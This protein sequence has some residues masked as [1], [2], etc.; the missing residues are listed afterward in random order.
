MVRRLWTVLV[1]L[2]LLRVTESRIPESL[3][4]YS[5]SPTYLPV[6]Y[7]LINTES[8]FFL[9]EATQDFMR[10]SSFLSRTEPLFIQQARKP[11]SLRASYGALFVEQP[12][13]L[14]LLQPSGSM[15]ASSTL[16]TFNWKV[17]TFILREKIHLDK[18]NIQVLFYIA[19]RDWDD[20]SIVD[21]LPC[22]RMF[23]FH[24]T[25]EV[26]AICRLQGELGACVAELEP[27]ASWFAPPS[28][29]PGRQKSSDL[30]EGNQV[31]LY[32]S[33]TS[34]QNSQCLGKDSA[35][36]NPGQPGQEE[37]FGSAASTPMR[38]IGSVRLFRTPA[39]PELAEQ[40]MDG[41]FAVLVPS[42]PVRPRES[43]S[44]FVAAAPYSPVEMFTL[45]V[46]L[47]EGVTFLGARPCNPMLWMISQDVRIEG[48]R[49]VTL[50]CRRKESSYTQR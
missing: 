28:V 26:R 8:S 6:Q 13:P 10:N 45:R 12:V 15:M 43:V 7:Q 3:Q 22:L 20:Y 16:F 5:F 36:R 31:A 17:Q 9:K 37:S 18:P 32:Y 33:L 39:V 1:I 47:K 14:E 30:T 40:R 41:N 38:R 27:P 11:P 19:G 2:G 4:R 48:H 25:Q 23:A 29:V 34:A 44:A 50:H 42:A 24:E 49:V 46:K 35:S 21:K